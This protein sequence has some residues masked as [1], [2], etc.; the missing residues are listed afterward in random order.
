MKCFTSC[1]ILGGINFFTDKAA[2]I[3]E[4]IRVAKPGNK[5]VIGDENEAL[6]QK[7]EELPVTSRFY[8]NRKTAISAPV[9]LLP[10]EMHD[11]RVKN[12][13]GGDMYCLSFTKS[14]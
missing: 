12:I 1:F 11:V 4:M 10:R 6:A 5:F 13:A 14:R 9:D 7:Y 3:R 2:V 8:G